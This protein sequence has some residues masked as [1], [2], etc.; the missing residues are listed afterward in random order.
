MLKLEKIEAEIQ[1]LEEDQRDVNLL[2]RTEVAVLEAQSL[3]ADDLEQAVNAVIEEVCSRWQIAREALMSRTR[4]EPIKTARQ[5]V[6]FVC[7][8]VPL[9]G[10]LI[11]TTLIGR[12]FGMNHASVLHGCHH[13]RDLM[14][15]DTDLNGH[16]QKV[17]ES[18]RSRLD[19]ATAVVKS[20]DDMKE[21]T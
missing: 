10:Q 11:P 3:S 4:C 5:V 2:L 14:D 6:F 19:K 7:R 9:K 18:Y 8:Q 16:V 13:V 17:L 1:A 15:T 21:H 20:D 12:V